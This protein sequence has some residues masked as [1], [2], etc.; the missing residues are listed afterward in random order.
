MKSLSIAL[1]DLTRSYRSTFALIFMFG[2]P[3]LVTGMFFLMFGNIKS[4]NTINIP[5]TLVTVVN[6]DKGNAQTGPLGQTIVD[7]LQNK[8]LASLMEITQINETAEARQMVESGKSGAAIII[9]ADFSESFIDPNAKVEIE[10][11]QDPTLTVG[12][13]IIKS[14]LNNMIDN[15]AGIKITT[16]EASKRVAE[17]SLKSNQIGPL[18][19]NYLTAILA[20]TAEEKLIDLHTPFSA[21]QKNAAAAMIGPIMAGMMIFFAFF[22]GVNTSSSILRED[23]EGT[24]PR[25][26][27]TPTS[28][29]EILHGK[30]IAVGLT[31]MIQVTVLIISARLLFGIEWGA[32]PALILAALSLIF[33]AGTFGIVICSFMKNTRQSGIVFGGLLT[34]TGML[35]MINIFTGNPQGSPLGIVPLFTP[36]G[37]VARSILGA[38]SGLPLENILPFVIG[39][40]AMSLVFFVVGV[41]RFQKRYA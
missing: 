23:E 19:Q 2:I 27:T 10:F 6:L 38:M 1:N 32:M 5:A 12:P 11:L 39:S 9:P 36:Q 16:S 25:L 22:T 37:W 13:M 34:V 7:S 4:T 21:P 26:F 28:Q 3:L 41:W 20:N 40:Y 14:V 29:S 24:L 31:I 30:F 33:S 35:G 8:Q 18:V 15:Y 17:G